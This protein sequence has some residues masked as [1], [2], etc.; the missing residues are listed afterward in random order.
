[1]KES[2]RSTALRM[3]DLRCSTVTISIFF[4]M[5]S[6][7][8]SYPAS[9]MPCA[10]VLHVEVQ[11]GGQTKSLYLLLLISRIASDSSEFLTHQK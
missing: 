3:T 11:S 5:L 4:M 9:G 10:S 6:S 7:R 8:A 2:N 1:M